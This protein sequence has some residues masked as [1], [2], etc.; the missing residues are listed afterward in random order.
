MSIITTAH[1]TSVPAKEAEDSGETT[2]QAGPS[3]APTTG[4]DRISEIAKQAAS[5]GELKELDFDEDDDEAMNEHARRGAQAAVQAALNKAAEFDKAAA[6]QQ[7]AAAASDAPMSNAPCA[8]TCV[9]L[10]TY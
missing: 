8:F 10:V 3:I 2:A 1:A 6:E 9:F 4:S 7:N 5:N